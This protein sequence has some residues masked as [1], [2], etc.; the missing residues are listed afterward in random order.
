LRQQ[1]C[2]P[3]VTSLQSQKQT[4]L[5][6]FIVAGILPLIGCAQ[7]ASIHKAPD[8]FAIVRE[9]VV[10]NPHNI[11]PIRSELDYTIVEVDGAPVTRETPP[12]WVDMQPGALV[13]AGTHHF[14]ARVQP[15]RLPL[16]YQPKDVSFA[17]TVESGK[18]YFLV[19]DKDDIPVLVEEWLGPVGMV[20]ASSVRLLPRLL[21]PLFPVLGFWMGRPS[22]DSATY[23]VRRETVSEVQAG[24]IADKAGL[25]TGDVIVAVNGTPVQGM[26]PFAL[27]EF[28]Q[29]KPPPGDTFD[30][31]FVVERG[32]LK[33]SQSVITFTAG[34]PGVGWAQPSRSLVDLESSD[35]GWGFELGDFAGRTLRSGIWSFEMYKI[36][37]GNPDVV[38][39]RVTRD[40]PSEAG[41]DDAVWRIPYHEPFEHT[42][43]L[44]TNW[45]LPEP[46]EHAKTAEDL[47]GKFMA[48]LSVR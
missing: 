45:S 13:S 20:P 1:S 8:G 23:T 33:K 46:A 28:L 5:T 40:S 17:A 34:N 44:F 2:G 48:D 31:Q 41:H 19:G 42:V 15:H 9:H 38:L 43:P 47:T 25:R 14:E 37:T 6:V 35:G 29:R 4:W 12:P 22:T 10:F 3:R 27:Q 18:V 16:G 21:P 26:Q 39:Y 30:Y 32:F 11:P 36:R 24:S 7:E